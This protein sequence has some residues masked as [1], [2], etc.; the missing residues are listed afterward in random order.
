M[1]LG[2]HRF[3]RHGYWLFPLG[4]TLCWLATL[5]G[6]LGLW[7]GKD[8]H[9]RY[10]STESNVVVF[11]SDVGASHLALF[12]PGC[13]LVFVFYV[14]SLVTERWL[15]HIERLPG[16]HGRR[17]LVL[18]LL[19]VVCGFIGGLAL[20]MLSIF[21]AFDYSTVH[22]S[23]TVLFVIF[24]ALSAIFQ[25][26]EVLLLGR[27][28]PDSRH[29][30]RNAILKIVIVTVAIIVA[31]AFAALYG[32][33]RGEGSLG[34]GRASNCDAITG[35]AGICEWTVSFILAGYF[36]TLILDLYPSWKTSPR[37]HGS[38]EKYLSAAGEANARAARDSDSYNS[39]QP[40]LP[41]M[42]EP[43]HPSMATQEKQYQP[44]MTGTQQQSHF[45]EAV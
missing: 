40:T 24:V 18:D 15:R 41:V 19:A 28:D 22:W 26:A 34:P 2:L 17:E 27:Y 4:A 25:T 13:A 35:A 44:A 37:H 31:I 29:L 3:T 30:K 14:S 33:C 16:T 32:K 9:R 10:R 1:A 12:I 38:D 43:T 20:L 23:M 21:N 11:V 8:D 42:M 5:G 39:A 45:G 6:L 7:L 36:A